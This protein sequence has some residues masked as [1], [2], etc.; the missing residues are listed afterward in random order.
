M[1]KRWKQLGSRIWQNKWETAVLVLVL[2]VQCFFVSQ[3][4]G[5]H[6]DELLSFELSNAQFNPW[7]VPTQPEGRLAKFVRNEIA[8]DSL[9][10]T[11]GNLAETGVDVLKNRGNSKLLSY[12]ADVYEEP[13][14]ISAEQFQDYLTVNGKDAFQYLSVYFNVKDDNHPPVHFMLLHTISSVWQNQVA[15][16]MGGVINI[17]ALLGCCILMMKLGREFEMPGAGVAAAALYGLSAG[18]IATVLLIRMYGVMTF[19]CVALFYIQM[20]KWKNRGF[21]SH[22]KVLILVTVLGFW[23]Q[24]FFLFYCIL[25]AA[26]MCIVLLREKRIRETAVYIRSMVT[27]AVIGVA[28]FPFAVSDVFSSGRGTE[29]LNNLVHG[30]NDYGMRLVAFGKI[31]LGRMT[32][33]KPWRLLLI[34]GVCLAV[35]TVYRT[36]WRSARRVQNKQELQKTRQ[37]TGVVLLLLPPLGYFLLAARMSPYLVDR[38]IMAVF[39]FCAM[40]GGY[41]LRKWG[42]SVDKSDKGW[43]GQALAAILVTLLCVGNVMDYDGTYLYRGYEKQRQVAE[44]YRDLP[45]ICVYDGVGYY[46]NLLE[47]TNYENTLLV[48]LEELEQRKETESIE[49][50]EQVVV[51]KKAGVDN[52]RLETILEEKYGLLPEKLLLENSVYGDA[53][54]LYAESERK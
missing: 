48:K 38:Y 23:T 14:W 34:A 9:G 27:A 19:F 32:G 41:L 5:Y 45:C 47:F 22:N 39:P 25:L 54:W 40:L 35:W 1:K 13:V 10:D 53:I 24:Y 51:L 30:G 7:I 15:P 29:A 2:L 4:E 20:K 11:L 12:K 21:E 46:E 16:F 36:W 42:V 37:Y 43:M 28:G 49:G 33:G 8:G 26:V 50:L 3:K 17:A 52:N 31:L 44:A 18:G 6:M